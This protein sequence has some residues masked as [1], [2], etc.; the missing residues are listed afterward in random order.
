[1]AAAPEVGRSSK[2]DPGA[3]APLLALVQ[4]RLAPLAE[5]CVE[6]FYASLVAGPDAPD[7]LGRLDDGEFAHLKKRQAE[8]L[9]SL[10]DPELDDAALVQSSRAA[11][12][13]H[14]MVGVE[15]DWYASAVLVY[16]RVLDDAL[17]DVL[18]ATVPG[19]TVPGET[20]PGE[21]VPGETVPGETLARAR[22]IV[23]RRVVLDM[24]G[25]LLGYREIDAEQ[26]RVLQRVNAV[27]ANAETVADLARGVLDAVA[28][29]DGIADGFFGRPDD[30]DLFQFEV[31]VGPGAE[32]F[33]S[34]ASRAGARPITV[35]STSESG[36]GPAGRA[37]RTGVVQRSDAYLTDP[38]TAP[39]HELGRRFHWR[40][41]AA[42]PLVDDSGTARALLSLYARW[43][44]Y[45]AYSSRVSFLALLQQTVSQALDRLEAQS[46]TASGILVFAERNAYL[47]M[48]ER[49]DVVMLYQPIVDLATGCLVKLE[50]LAR[51]RSGQ[52]STSSAVRDDELVNPAEFLPAF[53]DAELFRLFEIGL[54]QALAA[55]RCWLDLGVDT[56]VAIN[57]P[58]T[59]S[60]DGRY[61]DAVAGALAT[62]GIAPG[63]LT[64]ELLETAALDGGSGWHGE[65]LDE[66]RALGVRLAQDDLGSG[67]SSLL[68]LRTVE[69]DEVKIDQGIVRDAERSPRGALT[70]I[71][72]LTSLAHALGL[73]V[74][75]EGL[76]TDGLVEA[77]VFLG[78]DCGQ[79]YAIA[80]PLAS[81][82]VPAWAG[83]P[84]LEID[85]ERPRTRLGAL[86][87]HLA[88]ESRLAA[89]GSSRGL[90]DQA[91]EEP[92]GLARYLASHR[93]PGDAVR[94][95]RELHAAVAGGAAGEL[96]TSAWERLT[97]LLGSDS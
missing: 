80:R 64:L 71:Q 35:T 25:A 41:S 15:T 62:H 16:Q 14:A 63:Q 31:A 67:Y 46:G 13:I 33:I 75:V 95:H 84:A 55:L 93:E 88:W 69:F 65:A 32:A 59:A 82:H 77:A 29:L 6:R 50:A 18:G 70:F 42:V 68:R 5:S 40:S 61:H 91:I 58:T 94:A 97:G 22:A 89:L 56:G 60:S 43:P 78:A 76:E 57:L 17:G 66:L 37:W 52:A 19:E 28:D 10:L 72:P 9:R 21:T 7:V 85:R 45:F 79:G 3:D 54:A 83:R 96:H 24:K 73:R 48:L 23:G 38:S 4:A 74:T 81:S 2:S 47:D 39:W 53:G 51:L 27:A 26:S 92:C 11:G 34:G 1:M 86:A 90:H 30:D 36:L 49:G 12:R 44:G 20:V 8:H 87:A